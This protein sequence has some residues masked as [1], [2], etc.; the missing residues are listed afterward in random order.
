[1]NIL[2]EKLSQINAKMLN[3]KLRYYRE[4]EKNH[5]YR[6]WFKLESA[7]WKIIEDFLPLRYW[8]TSWKLFDW[9]WNLSKQIDII[10]YDKMF[11]ANIIFED[12]KDRY[13]P[14]EAVR[15]IIEV[16]SKFTKTS[17][18]QTIKNLESVR[19]LS[20]Y[21]RPC[22]WWVVYDDSKIQPVTYSLFCFEWPKKE[23]LDTLHNNFK[24]IHNKYWNKAHAYFPNMIVVN[25]H[26]MYQ[27]MNTDTRER[28]NKNNIYYTSINNAYQTNNSKFWLLKHKENTLYA[29]LFWILEDADNFPPITWH[30]TQIQLIWNNCDT[31]TK[32][33][34]NFN[35]IEKD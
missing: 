34:D 6:Q 17:Y 23:I 14:I 8:V 5:R 10:I 9:K 29:Y 19:K 35:F 22:I 32:N 2:F 33:M 28:D 4:I 20:R 3:E 30:Y 15:H 24:D 18:E 31:L 26:W 21:Y 1:M 27:F 13:I 16:K 11:S 7:L 25:N 12:W